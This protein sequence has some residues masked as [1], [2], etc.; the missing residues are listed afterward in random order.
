MMKHINHLSELGGILTGSTKQMH[1]E[2]GT[3]WANYIRMRILLLR[4]III[5]LLHY[6]S[7][8]LNGC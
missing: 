6:F 7:H 4:Q 1:L 5:S 2:N 8:E 3:V